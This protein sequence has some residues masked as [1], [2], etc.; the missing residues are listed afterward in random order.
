MVLNDAP[1]APAYTAH[2][3]ENGG[4]NGKKQK[5]YALPTRRE[6]DEDEKHGCQYSKEDQGKQP[7]KKLFCLEA[8]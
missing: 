5:A 7:R 2:E 3:E 4:A 1:N 6:K 8:E